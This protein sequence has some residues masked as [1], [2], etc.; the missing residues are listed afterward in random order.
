MGAT[1]STTKEQ[2]RELRNWKVVDAADVPV[3][4]LASQVASLLRGKDKV[5][6]TPHIDN[7]DFVVVV[8]A[9]KIKFTGNKLDQKRY[10]HHTGFIGG[11]KE[12]P[13]RKLLAEKPRE[14]VRLAVWGMLPKGP[15]GRRLINKLKVYNGAQHPHVAQKPAAVSLMVGKGRLAGKSKGGAAA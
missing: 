10:F 13:A 7:G 12:V 15:L 4:R 11:I 3:G 8:N 6:F 9:N 1:K 14:V 2:G 5:S